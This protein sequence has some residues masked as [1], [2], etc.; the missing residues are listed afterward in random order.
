MI[1]KRYRIEGFRKRLMQA[2]ADSNK[3]LVEISK[4]SGV[5]R[6]LLWAYLQDDTNPSIFTLA[7]LAETLEVSTD[8]LL[9]IEGRD[10]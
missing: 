10:K 3:T 4:Q 8:W 9:G 2:V 6:G 5:S 7:K 1:K